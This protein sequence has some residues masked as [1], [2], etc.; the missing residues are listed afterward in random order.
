MKSAVAVSVKGVEFRGG[1]HFLV[2][3]RLDAELVEPTFGIYTLDKRGNNLLRVDALRRGA[4]L[5]WMN[6]DADN[7]PQN[8]KVSALSLRHRRKSQTGGLLVQLLE[9]PAPR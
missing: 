8:D 7:R 1:I 5:Q 3:E 6:V 4:I 2:N 9:K